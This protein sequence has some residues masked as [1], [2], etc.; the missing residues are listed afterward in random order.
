[1]FDKVLTAPLEGVVFKRYVLL[2]EIHQ[3]LLFDVV[4]IINAFHVKAYF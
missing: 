4:Q 3:V 1:M 2:L